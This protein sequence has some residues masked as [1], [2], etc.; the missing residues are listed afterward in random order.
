MTD[1]LNRWRSRTRPQASFESLVAPHVEHLFRLAYR[2][3]GTTPGAEDLVQDVLVKLYRMQT[4]LERL[5]KPRPWLARVLYHEYVDRW[6]RERL[7]PVTLSSLEPEDIELSRNEPDLHPGA[8]PERQA[9]GSQLRDQLVA[10]I[11]LLNEDQ[12]A[13]ILFHDV[14]GYTL[15][16][17]SVVLDQPLGTLKSRIHRARAR[18]REHLCRVD[19]TFL[20]A[21]AFSLLG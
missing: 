12:R 3:T 15:E 5:D 13:V 8:D 9:I 21:D 19:A 17:L 11:A 7:A 10:A 6:R 20:T 1:F 16:E 18:L 2:F 14:E 4:E